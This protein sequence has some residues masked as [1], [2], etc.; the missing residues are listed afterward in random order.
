MGGPGSGRP[1]SAATLVKRHLGTEQRTPI[2]SMP[3]EMYIPN[4]SGVSNHKETLEAFDVRYR[5]TGDTIDISHDTNLAVTSPIVLTGDT[6]SLGTVDISANTNLAVTS[7]IVLTGDTV[8]LSYSTTNPWTGAN[9]FSQD[10]TLLSPAVLKGDRVMY[11]FNDATGATA[12][13]AATDDYFQVGDVTLSATKGIVMPRAGS[14][15]SITVIYDVTLASGGPP[16]ILTLRSFINGSTKLTVDGTAE[17]VA[18]NKELRTTAA[19]A[20]HT[21]AA[22][23]N[24]A[25]SFSFAGVKGAAISYNDVIATCEVVFDA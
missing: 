20:V 13:T 12:Q 10:V 11:Q 24:L 4:H 1:P 5:L 22:G 19:R 8:S 2:A 6:L 3:E 17:S 7:P 23:D 14:I 9:S 16:G 21:F 18:D 15:L 25:M